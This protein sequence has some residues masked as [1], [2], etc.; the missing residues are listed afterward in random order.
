MRLRNKILLWTFTVL[1]S[2]VLLFLVLLF[3]V[4]SL[5]DSGMVKKRIQTYVVQ[6]T[7]GTLDFQKAELI[8]YPLPHIAFRQ[9]SFSVPDKATGLV[10]LLMYIRTYGHLS[11]EM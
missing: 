10:Q 5:I 11:E 7:G 4:P 9:V 3:L 8:S 2:A 1:G 6:E